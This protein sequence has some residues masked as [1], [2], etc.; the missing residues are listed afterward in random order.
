MDKM[1]YVIIITL[2]LLIFGPILHILSLIFID[3]CMVKI[4]NIINKLS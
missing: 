2:L 1:D 3:I 4:Y